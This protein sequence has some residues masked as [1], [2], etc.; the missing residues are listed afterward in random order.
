MR[1]VASAESPRT[2]QTSAPPPAGGGQPTRV[3]DD[4][5]MTAADYDTVIALLGAE[6]VAEHE[7]LERRVTLARIVARTAA[8]AEQRTAA[9]LEVTRLER[10]LATSTG[11][12]EAR[13]R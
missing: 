12:R 2:H 9:R 6:E 1:Q 10:E 4:A 13:P 5:R 7:R 8:T 3:L 11:N